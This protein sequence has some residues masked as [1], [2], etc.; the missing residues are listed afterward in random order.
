MNLNIDK[1]DYFKWGGGGG[2]DPDP[3]PPPGSAHVWYAGNSL[4]HKM[5]HEFT[6]ET[7]Y[8]LPSVT[9]VTVTYNV[10]HK[11][12]QGYPH[13]KEKENISYRSFSFY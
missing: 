2:P 7:E 6:M 10:G 13:L 4:L 11:I 1:F 9:M 8:S 5:V 3:P 12:Y